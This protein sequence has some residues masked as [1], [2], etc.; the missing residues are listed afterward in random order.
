MNVSFLIICNSQHQFEKGLYLQK[1]LHHNVDVACVKFQPETLNIKKNLYFVQSV[2]DLIPKNNFYKRFIFF[3]ITPSKLSFEYLRSLRGSGKKVILIQET[4]Q[5][6]MSNGVINSIMISPDLI[7][8]ASDEEKSLMIKNKLFDENT[9]ISS[10]W[11]FQDKFHKFIRNE[12]VKSNQFHFKDYVLLVLSAPQRITS[13]S[14]ETYQKRKEII[15]W[16]RGNN[17]N[18]DILIKLH[19]LENMNQFLNLLKQDGDPLIHIASNNSNLFDLGNNAKSIVISDKTQAFIDFVNFDKKLIVYSIGRQN[20]ISSFLS[21]AVA[22]ENFRN[23]FFYSL[24]TPKESLGL[25]RSIYLKNEDKSLTSLLKNLD[26]PT[27]KINT[28]SI[29][30][31]TLWEYVYD[32]PNK[33]S[34]NKLRFLKKTLKLNDSFQNFDF[35]NFESEIQTIS[36]KTSI[37]IYLISKIINGNI[38][39]ENQIKDILH[40]F[41]TPH[42]VQYF[43]LETQRLKFFLNYARIKMEMQKDTMNIF[44]NSLRV[45]QEKSLLFKIIILIESKAKV[46][47]TYFVRTSVYKF[48]NFLMV[49]LIRLKR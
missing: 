3:S 40:N 26:S 23:I 6:S 47:T 12:L 7:L 16:I 13:S 33:L 5:L 15:Q 27:L 10:G 42:F 2:K 43:Y 36:M 44:K 41:I 34:S 49:I 14:Q 28:N 48:L 37:T 30:E 31:L 24:D 19:P 1:M 17:P 4:H 29:N 39:T 11:I 22:A 8:A 21:Q 46:F 38:N 18:A 9:I 25:F 32:G 20:F 45:I 35:K